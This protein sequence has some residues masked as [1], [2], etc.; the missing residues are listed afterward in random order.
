MLNTV[1]I[2]GVPFVNTDMDELV[3]HLDER[4]SRSEKT[5]L[6]T[7]NPEIMMHAERDSK[8][9]HI[10]KNS[11][12]VIPDGIGILIGAKILGTPIRQRLAGYDL[13]L[14]LLRL[15]AEQ[16]YS[17]YFLGSKPSVIEE[18]A[19]RVKASYPALAVAGSHHGYV[20]MDDESIIREIQST[21]PDVILVGLGFP[22]QERWIER[23]QAFLNKGLLIGVGG[24]FD[25]LAGK[26][27]RAPHVWRK[28]NVEWLY[29]LIQHPSR[30]R[31]MLVLPL[32][33]I[34]V[35][36]TRILRKKL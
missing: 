27:K 28:L 21:E 8:Y 7:A 34:R 5:F 2:M 23:Y 19:K 12:F 20:D 29:R 35:I 32:F 26:T 3:G 4:L 25:G 33:M 18:A 22:K 11:D 15:C 10:L 9:L 17:V 14:E 36:K 13:V 24:S 31:R 6:V 16:Q 30:W 1:E